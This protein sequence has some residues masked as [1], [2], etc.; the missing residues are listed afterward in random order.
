[1]RMIRADVRNKSLVLETARSAPGRSARQEL[2]RLRDEKD[3]A[4]GRRPR[5][6]RKAVERRCLACVR[7]ADL[8]AL[9][10]AWL[11][12]ASQSLQA[13]RLSEA[14]AASSL[15][16]LA[17]VQAAEVAFVKNVGVCGATLR[18]EASGLT[19]T[20]ALVTAKTLLIVDESNK[21]RRILKRGA[22]LH[23]LAPRAIT[24]WGDALLS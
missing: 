15:M 16:E 4:H 24:F 11:A 3:A 7:F 13:L 23:L 2:K 21:T 20:V 14:G 9:R 5:K 8:D 19:G 1:M 6:E 18:V 12:E 10:R 22:K 17:R